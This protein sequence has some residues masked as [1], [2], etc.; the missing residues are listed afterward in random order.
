MHISPQE[1]AAWLMIRR[2]RSTLCYVA[3]DLK[4]QGASE[5]LWVGRNQ[6]GI[7]GHFQTCRVPAWIVS[8]VCNDQEK[9]PRLA[10]EYLS[11][12]AFVLP[13]EMAFV[14][15]PRTLIRQ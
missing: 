10:P 4:A 1:P 11:A 7:D 2:R 12:R 5:S 8:G 14:G 3:R 13:I 6:S 15:I 9:E